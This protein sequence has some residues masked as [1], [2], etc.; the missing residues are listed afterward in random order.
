VLDIN[1][2]ETQLIFQCED[3]WVLKLDGKIALK[4]GAKYR[5]K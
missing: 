4:K 2:K 3:S 1:N 5:Q